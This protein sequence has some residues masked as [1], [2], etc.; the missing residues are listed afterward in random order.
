[1]AV[2][3]S[4]SYHYTAI[5]PARSADGGFECAMASADLP[6]SHL[7]ALTGA[8][9]LVGR[10]PHLTVRAAGL[11]PDASDDRPHVMRHAFTLRA[12]RMDGASVRAATFHLESTV[13]ERMEPG[14]TLHLVA[15]DDGAPGFS[16]LRAGRLVMAVGPLQSLPLGD[17][18]HVRWPTELRQEIAE[19]FRRRDPIYASEGLT[20][21]IFPM[22]LEVRVGDDTAL[23][24][25]LKRIVGEY[26]VALADRAT[27]AFG[28]P[29]GFGSMC[30]VGAGS[31]VGVTLTA[32]LLTQD[33]AFAIER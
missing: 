15:T 23:V 27:G 18:I 20:D 10:S 26:E 24:G 28:L 30:L 9:R 5:V 6:P 16:L 25:R 22:P 33:D 4:E 2:H 12:R 32:Q 7:P 1:M 8:L 29:T 11:H 14:D 31:R 19:L 21:A 3:P 13:V 17:G